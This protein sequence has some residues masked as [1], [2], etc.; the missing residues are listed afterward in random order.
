MR[1]I[2]LSNQKGGVGKSTTC[3]NLAAG[4]AQ[5]GHQVLLIDT[6]P[7]ANTTYSTIGHADPP[8]TIYD[9]LAGRVA[10]SQAI[11]RAKNIKIDV[12]PASIE[13]AGAEVELASAIGAQLRLRRSLTG[14][15]GLG[16]DFIL[17]DSP[18]SLGLLTV[19]ALAA[20]DEIII[21]VAGG[22]YGIRGLAQL[23]D[24]IEQVRELLATPQLK[25]AGILCTLMDHTNVAKDIESTLR[26]NYG[27]LVFN[28]TIPRNVVVEESHTRQQA[29]LDYA[30]NSKG[31]LAYQELTSEVLN[32]G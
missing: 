8:R 12:V 7:Q 26:Q 10:I 27:S 30:P 5:C 29:V 15:D 1:K 28:T 4:L 3:V 32:R 20:A 21:P 13:L 17:I 6:D 14:A 24:T 25:V 31:A 22:A 9:V 2:C 16:Y 23:L 18:P 11:T 19:N